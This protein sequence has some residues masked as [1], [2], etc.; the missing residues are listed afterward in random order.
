M[1]TVHYDSANS[2]FGIKKVN[3]SVDFLLVLREILIVQCLI[4]MVISLA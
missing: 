4:I 2:I 3:I 1:T